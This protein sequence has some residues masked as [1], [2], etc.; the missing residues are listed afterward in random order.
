MEPGYSRIRLGAKRNLQRRHV[1]LGGEELQL[2]LHLLDAAAHVAKFFGDIQRVLDRGRT[3]QD[4]KVLR[5]FGL[6]VTQVGIEVNVLP[7]DV[8]NFY[9]FPIDCGR[10]TLHLIHD[11]IEARGGNADGQSGRAATAVGLG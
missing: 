8:A 5:F 7:G 10:K 6:S 3:L 11:L 9:V 2:A 4:E 1:Y